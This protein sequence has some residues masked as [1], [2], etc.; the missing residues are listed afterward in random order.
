MG[1]RKRKDSYY[2]IIT[3]IGPKINQFQVFDVD[4]GTNSPYYGPRN[5]ICGE[6]WPDR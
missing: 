3:R 4:L 5:H 6:G 1:T 2:L